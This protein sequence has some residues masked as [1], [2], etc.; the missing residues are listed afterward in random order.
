L[1]LNAVGAG[2][3]FLDRYR[4]HTSLTGSPVGGGLQLRTFG[5]SRVSF[6]RQLLADLAADLLCAQL[7]EGWSAK[8][9]EARKKEIEQAAHDQAVALGVADSGSLVR[10]FFESI[11]EFLG[12]DLEARLGKVLTP[13][14]EG[15]TGGRTPPG[16]GVLAR[17][18]LE[19]L[20]DLLGQ[21]V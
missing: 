5:L 17:Q 21:G 4:H 16:A 8:L 11:G 6:P 15:K 12:G 3:P 7:V 9:D 1:Y 13:T 2:G 14:P 20:H 10:K 19:R 18:G